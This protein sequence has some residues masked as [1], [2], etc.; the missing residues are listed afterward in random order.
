MNIAVFVALAIAFYVVAFY[1][2]SVSNSFVLG[3][4]DWITGHRLVGVVILRYGNML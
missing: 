1:V 2:P 3:H 4:L